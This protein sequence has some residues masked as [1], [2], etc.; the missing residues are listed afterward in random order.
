MSFVVWLLLPA[1]PRRLFQGRQ[2]SSAAFMTPDLC[3]ALCGEGR[4]V[5]RGCRADTLCVLGSQEPASGLSVG[6]RVEA[7]GGVGRALY[8]FTDRVLQS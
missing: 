7:G 4:R 6:E 8:C 5:Q 2:S 1:A 3:P